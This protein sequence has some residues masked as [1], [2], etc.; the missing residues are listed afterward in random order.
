MSFRPYP[1]TDEKLERWLREGRGSGEGQTYIPWLQEGDVPPEM[2]HLER[3]PCSK[4]GRMAIT[5]ST[6]ELWARLYFDARKAVIGIEEQYPLDRETTR[7]IARGL[8]IQHPRDPRSHVDIV[9]TTDL[10]VRV[11]TADGR[12]VR[13]PRSCKAHDS[14][15][16]YNDAEHA[17]I[18]RRFWAEQG[19]EW[20]LI[21]NSPKCMTPQLIHNLDTLKKHRFT[22]EQQ[23]YVG[24]F[25][26]LCDDFVAHVSRNA[27][28][29]SLG[30]LAKQF[31]AYRGLSPG[32]APAV[33]LFLLH[34]ERLR[35]DLAGPPLLQQ[36]ALAVAHASSAAEETV[37]RRAA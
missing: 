16:D 35:G 22:P 9:I 15:A 10:V 8:A 30:D 23:P 3:V 29:I 4:S 34:Q 7:R 1:F 26:R 31:G 37:Q 18:E 33:A 25:E 24:Y 12:V 14:I 5:F 11:R 2:G 19:V 28:D 27:R 32:D 17:E 36:S 21:T 6:I 13:L 20:K